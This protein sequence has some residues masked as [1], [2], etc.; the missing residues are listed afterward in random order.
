MLKYK[1]LWKIYKKP[2]LGLVIFYFIFNFGKIIT[3]EVVYSNL[4]NHLEAHDSKI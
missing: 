3:K 1:N 2:V 4:E